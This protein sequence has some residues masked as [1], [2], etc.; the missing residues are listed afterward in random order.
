MWRLQFWCLE[1]INLAAL[2]GATDAGSQNYDGFIQ[3]QHP[4]GT[5][6]RIRVASLNELCDLDRLLLASAFPSGKWGDEY[7]CR[8]PQRGNEMV[9]AQGSSGCPVGRGGSVQWGA[10]G[11][12]GGVSSFLLVSVL[13]SLPCTA[14]KL[15]SKYLSLR[16]NLVSHHGVLVRT[17]ECY[18]TAPH[19]LDRHGRQGGVSLIGEAKKE[20]GDKL[21]AWFLPGALPPEGS[22]LST[23][24]RLLKRPY[25]VPA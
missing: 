12:D 19:H 10:G 9:C 15:R 21:P 17:C 6:P 3:K 11:C 8:T 14:W 23:L 25:A 16:T 24:S 4:L 1:S 5:P 20:P 13:H 7:T 2:P 22:P 18:W